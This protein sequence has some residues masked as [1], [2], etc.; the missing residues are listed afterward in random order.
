MIPKRLIDI[1]KATN[2]LGFR[3]KTTLEEGLA[4]TVAWYRSTLR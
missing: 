4:R 1:S 2:E 3:P